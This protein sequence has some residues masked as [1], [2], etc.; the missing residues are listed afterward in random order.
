MAFLSRKNNILEFIF[1]HAVKTLYNKT[2][3]ITLN[4]T[5]F[6]HVYLTAVELK[7]LFFSIDDVH[8]YHISYIENSHV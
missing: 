1:I 2:M 8:N 5:C 4:K 6:E 3:R 7:I